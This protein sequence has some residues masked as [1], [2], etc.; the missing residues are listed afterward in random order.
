MCNDRRSFDKDT[1]VN[2][3]IKTIVCTE[4]NKR[5]Y[6]ISSDNNTYLGLI[7]SSFD[8]AHDNIHKRTSI[9]TIYLHK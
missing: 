7:Y 6:Y 9:N 1:G 4:V 5:M 2:T 8:T 3:E